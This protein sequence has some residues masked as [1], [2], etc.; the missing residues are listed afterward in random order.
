M[1]PGEM[2]IESGDDV[3]Y[4]RRA[5]DPRQDTKR[6]TVMKKSMTMV[7]LLVTL[8]ALLCGCGK[9]ECQ[10]CGQEKTGRKYTAELFDTEFVCCGECKEALESL[11]YLID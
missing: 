11:E 1:V 2:K 6:G 10:M 9:F 7:L 5:W 4:D 8:A 3:R